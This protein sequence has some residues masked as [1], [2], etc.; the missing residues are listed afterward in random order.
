MFNFNSLASTCELG[1]EIDLFQGRMLKNK[2]IKEEEEES[3]GKGIT[4]C[5]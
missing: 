2:K 1:Y 5:T 3:K 4:K